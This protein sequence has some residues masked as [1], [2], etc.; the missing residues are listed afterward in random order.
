MEILTRE[1]HFLMETTRITFLNESTPAT[2]T[3][4]LISHYIINVC[5]EHCHTL[6]T[7][8]GFYTFHRDHWILYFSL[9][10]KSEPFVLWESLHCIAC[11]PP[12]SR[13]FETIL[14]QSRSVLTTVDT[15][16]NYL[17]LLP[18][19]PT[20]FSYTIVSFNLFQ[21]GSCLK[22]WLL[23]KLRPGGLQFKASPG[24]SSARPHPNEGLGTIVPLSS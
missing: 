2:T 15:F 10:P 16:S 11:Y 21:S 5:A 24:K 17:A 9:L 19:G 22:S 18:M 6:D 1:A 20:D 4:A 12:N 23:G 3:V 7:S 14:G 13:T 8:K